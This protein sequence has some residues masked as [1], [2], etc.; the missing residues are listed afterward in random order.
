MKLEVNPQISKHELEPVFIDSYASKV[1][2]NSGYY[3]FVLDFH[4]F[5]RHRMRHFVLEKQNLTHV[6]KKCDTHDAAFLELFYLNCIFVPKD[7]SSV[8]GWSFLK[9]NY[10]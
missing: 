8:V 7:W 4:F 5:L 10:V 9:A 2:E 3:A 1:S 6:T